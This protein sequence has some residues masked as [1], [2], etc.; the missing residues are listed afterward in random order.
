MLSFLVWLQQ[1]YLIV[2]VI[3]IRSAGLSFLK[4]EKKDLVPEEAFCLLD[5]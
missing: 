2:E 3:S 4:N 1:H 5:S